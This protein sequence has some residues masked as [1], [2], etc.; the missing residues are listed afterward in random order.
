[1]K[2]KPKGDSKLLTKLLTDQPTVPVR[3]LYRRQEPIKQTTYLSVGGGPGSLALGDQLR[4]R[5]V[6]TNEIIILGPD[7]NP[8]GHYQRLTRHSQISAHERLRSN[9]DSCPDNIWG[10]PSYGLQEIW[11]SVRQGHVGHALRIAVQVLGEPVLTDTFTPRAG[12][13]FAAMDREAH[14]IGWREMCHPGWAQVL[15][16]TDDG[17]YAVGSIRINQHGIREAQWVIARYVHLGMG[18]SRIRLLADVRG[19]RQRTQDFEHVVNAYESHDHIYDHLLKHGGVVIIRGRGITASRVIQRL[20]EVRTHRQQGDVAILHV[21]R[22]P[23]LAGHKDGLAR[24]RAENHVELQPFNWPKSTWGGPQRIRLERANDQE[25]ARLLEVWGGTTTA[26]RRDWRRIA[27]VGER[28]DWY[29]RYFGQTARIDRS[30][31]GRLT[32]HLSTGEPNRPEIDLTGDFLIDCTGLEGSVDSNPLLKDMVNT[33]QLELNP[34]GG[35]RVTNEFEIEGMSNGS[36]RVYASGIATL[37]GPH[38]AVDSFLGLQYAA[39]RSAESLAALGAPW[40][41]QLTPLRSFVQ[42]TR[43]VRG[44]RP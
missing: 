34:K 15:R 5:G 21:H 29:Q 38:A 18:Y 42:W 3:E 12:A 2:A 39:L 26:D 32:I 22:S 9:S 24:R 1:M 33:Y 44:V 11:H 14:R 43:F 13:V 4:L 10:F 37:G 36:G 41:Q 31:Q 27:Q 7:P 35:L 17:R 28:E 16:K 20:H 8:M 19:Y 6:P 23:V 30:A 25:R 40:V